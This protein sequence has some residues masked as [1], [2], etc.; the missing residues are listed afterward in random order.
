MNAMYGSRRGKVEDSH[1]IHIYHI[2]SIFSTHYPAFCPHSESYC[3]IEDLDRD[4]CDVPRLSGYELSCHK[5]LFCARAPGVPG[6]MLFVRHLSLRPMPSTQVYV[7]ATRLFSQG[8]N[9]T[10]IADP[11]RSLLVQWPSSRDNQSAKPI[12]VSCA[13]LQC[14]MIVKTGGGF[15]SNAT[16]G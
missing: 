12:C 6:A 4:G 2:M 11:V 14:E 8:H 15:P 3:S 9:V 16:D 5:H 13:H 10:K 7:V 1:I